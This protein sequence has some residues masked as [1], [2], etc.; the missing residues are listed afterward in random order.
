MPVLIQDVISSPYTLAVVF[1]SLMA[2]LSFVV[3]LRGFLGGLKQL[4]T[5]N[6]NAEHLEHMR[7]RAIWGVVLLAAL[8]IVWECVRWVAAL[9]QGRPL[10]D[11]AWVLMVGLFFAP[12]AVSYLLGV[13]LP[14]KKGGH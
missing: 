3:F 12:A 2:A 8:L 6:E 10:P 11:I 1:L 13:V 4:T 7:T 14:S 5:I 9:V